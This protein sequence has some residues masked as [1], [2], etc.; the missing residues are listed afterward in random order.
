MTVSW[1]WTRTLI[2]MG[3]FLLLNLLLTGMLASCGVPKS[4][5]PVNNRLSKRASKSETP[6]SS[7]QSPAGST[8]VREQRVVD[9]YLEKL[10]NES[11]AVVHDS[12]V[13]NVK[14][15]L[16]YTVRLASTGALE[17]VEISEGSGLLVCDSAVREALSRSTWRPCS[18][19]GKPVSCTFS[20]NF[21]LPT[22]YHRR[23]GA[24]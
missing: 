14:R 5:E 23:P 8:L 15:L 19:G 20:G 17:T 4:P 6:Q 12:C 13:G 21:A 3:R 24:M 10:H 18:A 11:L 1:T 9:G 22:S 7:S 2:N 16:K